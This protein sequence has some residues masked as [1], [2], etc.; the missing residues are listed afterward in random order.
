[1]NVVL[2]H[3]IILDMAEN[4]RN[5]GSYPITIWIDPENPERHEACLS[6]YFVNLSADA[7]GA[8]RL[9]IAE[10]VITVPVPIEVHSEPYSS[11][12]TDWDINPVPPSTTTPIPPRI[13][14]ELPP[15]S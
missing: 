3:A 12:L 10:E 4:E 2:K 8:M 11:F 5:P 1:L 13:P 9:A 15:T 7:I 14:S 6:E